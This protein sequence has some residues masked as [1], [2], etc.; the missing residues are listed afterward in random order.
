V[1]A[2]VDFT[3]HTHQSLGSFAADVVEGLVSGAIVWAVVAGL[4]GLCS[5]PQ[6]PAPAPPPSD[7]DATRADFEQRW[8]KWRE[9]IAQE[10]PPAP[11]P[12]RSAG[13]EDWAWLNSMAGKLDEDFVDAVREGVAEQERPALEKLFR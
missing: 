4:I 11:T 3:E 6:P 12:P 2:L 5:R 9:L 1:I 7:A 10:D 8:N 13:A